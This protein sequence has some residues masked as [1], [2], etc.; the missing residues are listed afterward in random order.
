MDASVISGVYLFSFVSTIVFGL[1]VLGFL[2]FLTCG[3][4]SFSGHM[5]VDLSVGYWA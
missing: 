1:V 3:K 2:P 5:I 4:I